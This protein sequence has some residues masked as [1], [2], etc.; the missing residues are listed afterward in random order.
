MNCMKRLTSLFVMMC[1]LLGS[2]ILPVSAAQK[3]EIIY[4]VGRVTASKL[5]LYSKADS[6]S[7]VLATAEKGEYV[8]VI[9][10][11][12]T[13]G[14]FRVNYNLEEGYMKKKE[15]DIQ[16]RQDIELGY[17]K[18]NESI[19]Y[20]RSGP[21]T[22]YSI[23]HSGFR[24]KK[25]YII[26]LEK[27]W[28]KVL[29]ND[30]TCYVRSDLMDL[31]E[32]PYENKASEEKPKYFKDGKPISE[33]DYKESESVAVAEKGGY[34]APINGPAILA[35]AQKFIGVPYVFGGYSPAGFD[36][37]GL[38]YY[39]LTEMGYPAHRTAADQYQMGYSIKKE[40][41]HPGDLVFFSNTYKGGISHVGIYAGNGKFLHA[42]KEGSSVSYSNL[43]GY[44]ADHYYGARR[45]SQ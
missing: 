14:W 1:L 7:K 20:M 37:S 36:C 25:Y 19:V 15:L 32:V 6:E 29:R 4:G 42:P 35:R 39:I 33:T 44:W 38:V 43:S 45:I 18:I 24:D 11:S 16:K 21:G 12:S 26:G 22:E 40:N 41:L 27:G 5:K 23:L 30:A 8:V 28:Y 31:T 34:Y 13:D 3:E 17:G 2:F 10:K 9:R